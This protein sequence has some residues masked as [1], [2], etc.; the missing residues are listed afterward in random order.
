MKVN[1]LRTEGYF[2]KSE[3]LISKL[4][5]LCL[6]LIAA[7]NLSGQDLHNSK[8]E[9]G[10]I[11]GAKYRIIFPEKWENKLI[12]FA[13]GYE[14]MGSLPRQSQNDDWLKQ[15]TPYTE[16][17]F[18]VAAS[19][20][21]LQGWALPE[22]VDE[23]EALREYFY[24]TYGN[25]DSTFMVGGSMG[26]GITL[27]VMENFGDNYDGALALCP[28]SSRPYLQ[29]RRAFDMVAVFN[30]LF[31]GIFPSLKDIL[32]FSK[33]NQAQDMRAM[34]TRGNEIL[35]I[36]LERDSTLALDFAKRFDLKIN[37]VPM[38]MMFNET[39]L[40]DVAQKACGNPYD[41]TNT[42]YSGFN[43][44]LE[45]NEKIER[46]ASNADPE[47]IFGKYDRTGKIDKPVLVMHTLYD[48]LIPVAY[49][50]TNFEHMIHKQ[51]REQY[52]STKYT[53]GQGHCAFTNEQIAHAF[54]GLRAW[55]KSGKKADSGLIK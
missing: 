48:Q 8:V 26:G 31:P 18:A 16:R 14:P 54:D 39:I 7:T 35:T 30:V 32:D 2:E 38:N 6:V 1:Y 5:S 27:A 44:D 42:V 43:N 55:V 52:F 11:N 33:S 45:L 51:G 15:M 49:G 36:I 37:D 22:G 9:T 21:S 17:G 25:P 34:F 12:M 29:T 10:E 47:F 23:T 24:D 4:L 40:K 28:L 3:M 19:D 53:N 13:H 50:I 46:L 20:Y 41:N